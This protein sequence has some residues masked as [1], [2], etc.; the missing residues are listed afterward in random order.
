VY[1]GD[2]ATEYDRIHSYE[3]DA[4][5]EYPARALVSL[6]WGADASGYGDALELGAGS[7]YFTALIARRARSVI[8]IEPVEDLQKVVR[9]R[10]EAERLHNVRVISSRAFDLGSDVPSGSVDSA[11]I[12][13]SLHH[14]H[15]RPDVFAELGR[16]VRPGGRLYLVEPHHNVRRVARLVRK[17]HRSYRHQG[18]WADEKNWATHDFLTRGELRALCRQAGFENPHIEA[19]WIPY[20]R[21]LVP[22]PER[23]LRVERILGRI[24][25]VRHAGSILAMQARRKA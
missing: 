6:V 22:S 1:S 15:R 13:Q 19:Y 16:I 11:F 21:R 25:V 18:S 12:I 20:S 5:H 7:G 8:A 23:R 2:G 9:D 14:F 17:Y 3:D 24:P 10:C 4:Q